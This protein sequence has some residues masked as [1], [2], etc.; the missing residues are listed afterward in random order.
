M[1]LE[2]VENSSLNHEMVTLSCHTF[3]IYNPF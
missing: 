1:N 3:G 2:N